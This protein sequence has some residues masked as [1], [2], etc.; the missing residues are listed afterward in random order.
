M[1][2]NPLQNRLTPLGEIV[3]IPQRG[4]LMGNR[5]CLHGD[6]G[7]IRHRWKGKRWITCSLEYKNNRVPLRS[8]GRYTP[9][10]FK[11]EVSALAVGHRPCAQCRREQY[12]AF[13]AAVERSKGLNPGS[14][15]ADDLD[16][17]LH[18]ERTDKLGDRQR[19]NNARQADL[20]SG[21]IFIKEGAIFE[22]E[23][24]E[25]IAWEWDGYRCGTDLPG[26]IP[27]TPPTIIEAIRAGYRPA[28]REQRGE[29]D[30]RQ[31]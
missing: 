8:S 13:A 31:S 10:F 24:S 9:L 25:P 28:V 29:L 27:V 30:F 4:L 1:N 21:T 23:N 17:W 22:V 6:D 26:I 14:L 16:D 19:L 20:P 11:D 18:R 5:G 7:I 15:R 12:N 2:E 3:A